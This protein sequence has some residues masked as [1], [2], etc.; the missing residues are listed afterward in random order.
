MAASDKGFEIAR[1][2][3]GYYPI[4]RVTC[5]FSRDTLEEFDAHTAEFCRRIMQF[6][7]GLPHAEPLEY[8][9]ASELKYM[10]L[11]INRSA[12]RVDS[13]INHENLGGPDY[14][15]IVKLLLDCDFNDLATDKAPAPLKWSY[16]L[17][18]IVKSI[19]TYLKPANICVPTTK[20]FYTMPVPQKSVVKT[21]YAI[22]HDILSKTIRASPRQKLVCWIPISFERTGPDSPVN[23]VGVMLF[24]FKR[25]MN[26]GELV[27]ELEFNKHTVLGSKTL[28]DSFAGGTE[29]GQEK[30]THLKK[31]VD[32]VLSMLHTKP[33]SVQPVID[34]D[35]IAVYFGKEMST[36]YN[37]PLYIFTITVKDKIHV[38][39]SVSVA[40]FNTRE[41]CQ[42]VGGKILI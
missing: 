13:F 2:E 8:G 19:G 30:N 41:L 15:N 7:A 21:K 25:D 42:S 37:Y 3:K 20:I 38:T 32:V 34:P 14:I 11:R 33:T 18:F 6:K 29:T 16:S 9:E 35:E 31:R 24:E 4:Q 17:S 36:S 1:R 27:S 40:D 5:Y 22:I 10:Q 28:L 39:N 23:N 12:R 26:L